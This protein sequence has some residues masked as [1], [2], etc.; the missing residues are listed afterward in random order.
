MGREVVSSRDVKESSWL[1]SDEVFSTEVEI[2]RPRDYGQGSGGGGFGT[3]AAG[4]D[5]QA[6]VEAYAKEKPRPASP[7]SSGKDDYTSRLMKYV[8][9]E[10]V[11]LFITLD[12]LARSSSKIPALVH[13]GILVFGIVG[14]YLYLWR[15]GKVRK[16]MQLHIS[17]VAFCV[18]VFA[19]GGPFSQLAWYDPI[20]GGLLLPAYTF[21]VAIIEA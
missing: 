19:I 3:H 4:D 2:P 20:Y 14:T 1:A 5:L 11:A 8:P 6:E 18:W 12:T 7:P 15:I 9:A 10:I 13:W 21:V 16:Q 17:A